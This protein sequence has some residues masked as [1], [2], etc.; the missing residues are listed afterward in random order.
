MIKISNLIADL[1]FLGKK[2]I[3]ISDERIWQN[4][5]KFFIGDFSNALILK[6]PKPNE[7]NLNK[8]LS[9]VKSSYLI[10]ALGS[11]TINDLC[12]IVSA[13]S[14]IPYM[15]IASAAS[16]NGYLSKNAS[17][18]ISGHK[19][20]VLATL[21][22]AVFCDVK[23]LK[24][25]PLELTKAGIGDIMCFYSCWFDWY[26]SHLILGT[27]F[28]DEPFKLIAKQMKFFLK[29][30]RKFSLKNEEFL[31]I[32]IEML[33]LSGVG[34]TMAG[35]S[36][37]ASQ[38]EHLI[39]HTIEMKYPKIIG[40]IF[41]GAQIAI[42]T[43]TSAKLQKKLL[44]KDVL[45]LVLEDFPQRGLEKFFNQKI[46]SQCR[47]EYHKK[48]INYDKINISLQK[49]WKNY[50]K[51][52]AKIHLNE[53]RLKAIFSHFKIKTSVQ[54]LGLSDQQYQDC[55]IN[56]KFIRNRFTC[57]DIIPFSIF[58]NTFTRNIFE[59]KI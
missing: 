44:Q 30:Y 54:S 8:I 15:I 9:R 10:I 40:K 57:L 17:I 2:V 33:L 39:A 51:K 47:E 55:V 53:S 52:L 36:Y 5:Q 32:L 34:M 6:D 16:M 59:D 23:I 12:K 56:A 58:K 46:A 28:D 26:L 7:E 25:A 19:K 31:K 38:S 49:N 14:K 11:G 35:G 43:L 45:K 4:C 24:S 42:T 3:F 13:R 41:H 18:I 20:T 48:I 50:R 27:K 21:P 37:P 22:I 1:G 29:N